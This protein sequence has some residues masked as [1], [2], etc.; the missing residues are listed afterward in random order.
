MLKLSR[1]RQLQEHTEQNRLLRSNN[2]TDVSCMGTVDTESN[3]LRVFTVCACVAL[4][5]CHYPCPTF[6]QPAVLLLLFLHSLF[7]PLKETCSDNG[8][9][10]PGELQINTV[11]LSR[12]QLPC[13]LMDYMSVLY[14][15]AH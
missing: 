13:I 6:C 10:M 4:H 14:V 8:G 2:V 9:Q 12:S 1:I 11:Y 5:R 15:I 3:Q 7:C